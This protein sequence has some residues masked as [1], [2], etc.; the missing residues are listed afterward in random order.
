MDNIQDHYT[1]S[2]PGL[3]RMILRLEDL[4]IRLDRDLHR[5]LQS[6]DILFI[7]FAFRW[8]NCILLRELPLGC[9]FRLWDTYL[10]EDR[11][12]FENFH[13]YVCLVLLVKTFRDRLMHMPFQEL[14]IFLQNLPTE[15]WSEENMEPI[16]AEAF[17]FS[18][19][20]EHA[21]S[22]LNQAMPSTNL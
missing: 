1:F 15:D 4:V 2:Q 14:I 11:G 20:F 17:I 12:G 9:I 7:Q 18:T 13:V 10:S 19:L 22:H 6:Q 8:M 21:P 16:L 5:H 3:Q